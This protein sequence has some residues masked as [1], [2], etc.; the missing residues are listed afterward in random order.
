MPYRHPVAVT[1]SALWWGLYLGCLGA[2][3]GSLVGALT[4]RAPA[5]PSRVSG[6]AGELP[7]WENLP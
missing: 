6:G 3:I 2:G 7:N 4:K 1:I 5:A